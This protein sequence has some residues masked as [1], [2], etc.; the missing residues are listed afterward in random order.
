MWKHLLWK[1]A[2]ISFN[3]LSANFKPFTKMIFISLSFLLY[4]YFRSLL[5]WFYHFRISEIKIFYE[6]RILI[7]IKHFICYVYHCLSFTF[8]FL[9]YTFISVFNEIF[10]IKKVEIYIIKVCIDCHFN[11]IFL[12]FISF[13]NSAWLCTLNKILTCNS[14]LPL[15]N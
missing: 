6:N 14:F 2:C 11:T 12:Y 3:H 4:R 9:K 7:L 15:P 1:V 8:W 13:D 10:Y 5:M